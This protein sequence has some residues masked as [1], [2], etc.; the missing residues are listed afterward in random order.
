MNFHQYIILAFCC[1]IA[2][3]LAKN[4]PALTAARQEELEEVYR[5][6]SKAFSRENVPALRT[7]FESR[8]DEIREAQEH[9]LLSKCLVADLIYKKPEKIRAF[10]AL[11]AEFG[12]AMSPA[13]FYNDF[14]YLWRPYLDTNISIRAFHDFVRFKILRLEDLWLFAVKAEIYDLFNWL[15]E[16]KAYVNFRIPHPRFDFY[17]VAAFCYE[18][19]RLKMLNAQSHSCTRRRC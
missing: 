17:T 12:I 16:Q 7:L 3:I 9:S 2:S 18:T 5:Q 6:A 1:A 4:A 11:F 13:N 10:V 19:G 15:L 14:D 8:G